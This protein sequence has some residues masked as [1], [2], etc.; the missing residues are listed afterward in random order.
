MPL[1]TP[2][3]SVEIIA[4]TSCFSWSPALAAP[5]W[6]TPRLCAQLSSF[7]TPSLA[8]SEIAACCEVMPPITSKIIA[9]AAAMIASRTSTAASAR[10][11]W[12]V[13]R[14]TSGEVTAATIIAPTTGAVIV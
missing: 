1:I 8:C 3:V 10:G 2:L 5:A 6:S 9:T 13:S 11:M 4:G 12:R 7:V 14:A